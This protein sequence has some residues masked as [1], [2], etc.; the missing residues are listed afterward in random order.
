MQVSANGDLAN[1]MIPGAGQ[2]MGGAM[3]LVA[4]VKTRD[5][6][7]GAHRQKKTVPAKNSKFCPDAPPP[8][9]G[10]RV[11]NRII[12][13]WA[14]DVT[15]AASPSSSTPEVSLEYAQSKTVCH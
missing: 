4:G 8:L 9:T 6:S 2:G 3:D 14:F 5:Y 13:I 10:V 7:D 12:S 11:V 1:W 15:D